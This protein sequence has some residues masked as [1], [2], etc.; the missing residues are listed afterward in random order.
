M[1]DSWTSTSRFAED[2][3][4]ASGR[5][6][7]EACLVD[8]PCV[9]ASFAYCV[10]ALGAL[11]ASWTWLRGGLPRPRT[12]R[13]LI[14]LVGA[15]RALAVDLGLSLLVMALGGLAAVAP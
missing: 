4:L 6:S 3:R 13:L 14:E 2:A 1:P 15:E 12:D 8:P 9:E 10:C 5:P 11:L 7:A